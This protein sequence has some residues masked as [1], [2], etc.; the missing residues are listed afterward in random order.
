MEIPTAT[1]KI[2]K[3]TLDGRTAYVCP[4]CYKAVCPDC[5][6]KN[7]GLCRRCFSLLERFS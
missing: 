2:C 5:A 4:D 1:C 3:K 7:D 6:Q